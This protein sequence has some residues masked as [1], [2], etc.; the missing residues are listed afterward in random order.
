MEQVLSNIR[1]IRELHSRVITLLLCLSATLL[2][3][4]I[5]R[6]GLSVTVGGETLPGVYRLSDV[7][8]TVYAVR[9]AA[10]ELLGG[11]AAVTVDWSL[12]PGLYAGDYQTDL[13][14]LQRALLEQVP[15]IAYLC[16]IKVDG[17]LIGWVYDPSVLG[18]VLEV[19]LAEQVTPDTVWAGFAQEVTMEYSYAPEGE[20]Y[21]MMEVSAKLR[22]CLAVEVVNVP[23][24]APTAA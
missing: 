2:L 15:G 10:T 12:R 14:T 7:V 13:R 23:P 20:A 5:L 4:T 16:G 1:P 6:P 19:M 8:R 24:A 21:D 22:D 11:D 17:E 3:L 18:E 9:G